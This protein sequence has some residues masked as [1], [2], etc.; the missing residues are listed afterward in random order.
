ML[1]LY[2]NHFNLR[3]VLGFHSNSLSKVKPVVSLKTTTPGR[4]IKRRQSGT[5]TTLKMKS[6]AL[7]QQ[8]RSTS[9][10]SRLNLSTSRSAVK[11]SPVKE[12]AKLSLKSNS[13]RESSVF[14][15]LGFNA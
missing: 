4:I 1:L 15:R 9:V 14:E 13:S 6:D 5:P 12:F 7:M 11:T 10:K 2:I 8:R 3:C